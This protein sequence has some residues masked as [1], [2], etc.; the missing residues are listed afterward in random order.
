[1][2]GNYVDEIENLFK[3]KYSG[4]FYVANHGYYLWVYKTSNS[5]AVVIIHGQGVEDNPFEVILLKVDNDKTVRKEFYTYDKL[6]SYL[7][8]DL[9]DDIMVYEI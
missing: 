6:K 8:N 7:M 5:E 1:M 9:L 3:E 4:R 2:K